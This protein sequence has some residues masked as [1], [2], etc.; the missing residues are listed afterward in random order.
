M[1]TLV[2]T[3]SLL[4]MAGIL[5]TC[6]NAVDVKD[7]G[8]G[9][10]VGVKGIVQARVQFLNDATVDNP[11]V[12]EDDTWDPIRGSKG[13]AE[14][15]RFGLRRA[16]FS[17]EAAYKDNWKGNLTFRADKA[18]LTS[19]SGVNA[20]LYYAWVARTFKTDSLTHEF[21]L[22]LDKP[23]NNESSIS[24]ST[25][26]F[27]NDRETSAK[28]EYRGAGL[29]YKLGGSFFNLGF[30]WMNGGT[31]AKAAAAGD[32]LGNE[33]TAGHFYS[34][35]LE[36]SP[37]ADL[38]IAKKGE[39]YA[40]VEV[41]AGVV[42]GFDWQREDGRIGS[43]VTLP[44]WDPTT[45]PIT[46]EAVNT[47]FSYS[48]QRTT[49]FGPDILARFKGL[50]FLAE[51]RWRGT[52]V[53]GVSN[54][55]FADTSYRS[56]FWNAQLAYA[57]PLESGIAIEPAFRYTETDLDISDDLR[58]ETAVLAYDN[59]PKWE[60]YQYKGENG[61]MSGRQIDLGVNCYWKGQTSKTQ[62][63]YSRW[64]GEQ[65]GAKANIVYLQHQLSF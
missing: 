32:N 11:G 41:P 51:M 26:I 62:L 4:A 52:D 64:T 14:F 29:A 38:W 33:S 56:H 42:I 61:A 58:D 3:L 8:A 7:D 63:S 20:E 25:Y 55:A 47:A 30:D 10:K 39:S 45:S 6:L 9:L 27:A 24:S 15:A 60:S 1:R 50:T 5:P 13:E 18:G 35:R 44:T 31:A 19:S 2:P 53:T 12:L 22:G 17:F 21:K 37:G 48:E 36:F 49:T 16:R 54:T 59:L 28:I 43:G 34:F 46:G 40:G 65:G 23:F 57:F